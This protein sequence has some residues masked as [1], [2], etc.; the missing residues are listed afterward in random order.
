MDFKIM[1]NDITYFFLVFKVF[2]STIFLAGINKAIAL[3]ILFNIGA[4]C[5]T[6]N[7]IKTNN[8]VLIEM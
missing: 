6:I 8:I 7:T 4:L 3:E 5:T 2:N 1:E